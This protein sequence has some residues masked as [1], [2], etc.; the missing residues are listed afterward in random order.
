M[1]RL[2]SKSKYLAGLQ[3]SK[4]LWHHYH[5]RDA[6]PAVDAGQQAIFDQGH[7]V[8]EWAKRLFPGGIEVADGNLDL[9]ETVAET[10][11]LL[12]RRVP[13]YE[14]AFNHGNAYARSD[15]LVPVEDGQWDLY[16][17]KSGT[18]VKDINRDDVAFQLH[19]LT[20]AG[21]RIRKCYLTHVN[22]QYVRSGAIDPQQ[23]M[24]SEDVSEDA[25]ERLSQVAVLLAEQSNAIE[26]AESPEVTIGP[27]C[28]NP[29]A[30]PMKSCCWDDLPTHN[31]FH[32]Y[33]GGKKSWRMFED[34]VNA[35][36]DAPEDALNAKQALQLEAVR[37]EEPHI[38]PDG[39][40]RF[41]DSLEYP[42]FYLDF[43][44]FSTA[45][46]LF[47]G[48]RPYRQ[49]PFQFSLHTQAQPGGELVHHGFLAANRADPRAEFM[50]RLREVLDSRGSV[51]VYNAPFEVGRL[52]ETAQF[53]PEYQPWVDAVEARIVD[54]LKPF[55]AFDYYHPDQQGSAS[56]KA[57]L[58]A[59]VG[60]SYDELE[61][62]EGG[63][64]S[65]EFMR[66]TF[67]DVEPSDRER[68]RLALEIYCGMDTEAMAWIV[69]KLRGFIAG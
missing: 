26:A 14:A 17:V 43:E 42:L 35:L 56:I 3:C 8:G 52:R 51:V 33:R 65:L 36:V 45:V 54:L 57:V 46:P 10:A 38:N 63:T 5:A 59:L 21:L 40:Q 53:L 29:Y 50:Q 13:L 62:K 41:L 32:L 22:N 12:E 61:I 20:G 44:T 58:P 55:R 34:G 67:G 69:E 1:P 16:E 49:I 18:S 7:E 4:L 30:C 15:I 11:R 2:I 68:V 31:V 23:L 19:V 25:R 48:V 37:T 39:I 64:A 24:H 27:H 60:R 28:S 47:D 9:R 66:V 6:F